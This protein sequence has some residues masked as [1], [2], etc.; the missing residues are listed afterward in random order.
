M[1][2]Q[3]SFYIRRSTGFTLVEMLVSIVLLAL[4]LVVLTETT[5][6][7]RV[8][9]TQT[10]SGIQEFQSARNAFE[11]MT[12]RI[13]QA[14]LNGYN[15]TAAN[16]PLVVA[17]PSIVPGYTRASELRFISGPAS[18]SQTA[19]NGASGPLFTSTTPYHPTHAIFFQAPLGKFSASPG[20]AN[21]VQMMNTCGYYIEWNTDTAAGL[22]ILP[23][24]L[25][26]AT[27]PARWRFRLMEMIEPSD[28]L[29]IY[30]YT[31][32]SNGASS[33]ASKS[34]TYNGKDW[35]QTPVANSAYCRPVADNIIL[36]AFLPMVSPQSATYPPGGAP[37]GTSTDLMN[38]PSAALNGSS[39]YLYDTAP[40]QT[41]PIPASQ[42][43][44][45]PMVYVLM[46]AVDE[47]SFTTYQ[48]RRSNSS[49]I[50]TDLGVDSSSASSFLTVSNYTNRQNDIATVTNALQAAHIKYRIFSTVVPLTSH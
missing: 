13:S 48:L 25:P 23:S 29:T 12:R 42:N 6:A 39:G 3:S 49:A 44:L 10:T 32:G 20:A 31:S 21:L 8:A 4:I 18:L 45:P 2:V 19:V 36:L 46:I 17:N 50:P 11:V 43:Q 41:A 5:A 27:Y 47:K 37:D 34:W 14:T 38:S 40:A 35:F 24:F 33:P 30:N 26:A 28:A 16:T 7:L 22:G 9:V 15:D 1:T